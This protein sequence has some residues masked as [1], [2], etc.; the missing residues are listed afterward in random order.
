MGCSDSIMLGCLDILG[1][2]GHGSVS[3]TG[4]R[5]GEHPQTLER[6]RDAG[7]VG[8]A[9]TGASARMYARHFSVYPFNSIV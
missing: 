7:D 2:G 1:V 8:G 4:Q 3:K 5:R 9:L 6:K